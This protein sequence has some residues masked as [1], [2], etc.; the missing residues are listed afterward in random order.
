LIPAVAHPI[1]V[2]QNAGLYFKADL[3]GRVLKMAGE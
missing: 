3:I 1:A 2:L